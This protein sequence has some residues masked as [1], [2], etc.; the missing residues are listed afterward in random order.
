MGMEPEILVVDL[1]PSWTGRFTVVASA[2][3]RVVVLRADHDRLDELSARSRL[4]VG[5][6]SDGTV[7]QRGDLSVV[8][9]LDAGARLFVEAWQTPRATKTG[10]LGDGASWDQAGFEPPDLPQPH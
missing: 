3:P 2:P 9:E 1:D 10:R 8:D 6:S 5:R 7:E 4:V